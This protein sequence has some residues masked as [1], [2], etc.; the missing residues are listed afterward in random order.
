MLFGTVPGPGL[1]EVLRHDSQLA[2]VTIEVGAA[3]PGAVWLMSRRKHAQMPRVAG[4]DYGC[5]DP[6][7]ARSASTARAALRP[8]T[9]ITLPPGWVAAPQR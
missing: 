9:A 8:L 1:T 2:D 7:A 6:R 3:L 5:S 4:T